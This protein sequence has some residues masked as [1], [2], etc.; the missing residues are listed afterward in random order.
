LEIKTESNEFGRRLDRTTN[1]RQNLLKII[2]SDGGW[3]R[4]GYPHGYIFGIL[5]IYLFALACFQSLSL[6][7]NDF[8]DL[9]ELDFQDFEQQ[10]AGEQGK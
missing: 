7:A 2:D 6:G 8:W 4:D 3:T 5:F 9:Q 10:L 1:S